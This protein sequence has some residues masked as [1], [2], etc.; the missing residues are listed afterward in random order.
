MVVC[1]IIPVVMMWHLLKTIVIIDILQ[2]F[3]TYQFNGF[4]AIDMTF[5]V[6]YLNEKLT[7]LL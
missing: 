3:L 6:S 5:F 7:I 4:D 2:N 1:Y